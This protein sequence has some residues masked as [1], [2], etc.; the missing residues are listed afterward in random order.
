[1]RRL[2]SPRTA[3]RPSSQPLRL[4]PVIPCSGARVLLRV[5]APPF[6]ARRRRRVAWPRGL[7]V[8]PCAV[9]EV[10]G[11][12]AD[13]ALRRPGRGHPACRDPRPSQHSLG[14]WCV[15]AP[16]ADTGRAPGGERTGRVAGAPCC[17]GR[18]LLDSHGSR[19]DGW[20]HWDHWDHRD[21]GLVERPPDL[22]WKS[23]AK[24]GS[25]ACPWRVR[26]PAGWRR[27]GPGCWPCGAVAVQDT[28]HGAA[29]ALR[30]KPTRPPA[31]H[32]AAPTCGRGER[33][34]RGPLGGAARAGRIDSCGPPYTL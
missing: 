32:G 29:A 15:P 31:S 16:M 24:T 3:A 6:A 26:H 8:P 21:H 22:A 28:G 14:A 7:G 12:S 34:G 13:R 18:A 4:R 30:G 11:H 1:M 2:P 25:R 17:P 23:S 10:P 19:P 33:H 27:R 20:D 5:P 9:T